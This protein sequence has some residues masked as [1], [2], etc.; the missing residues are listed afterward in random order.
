MQ[1]ALPAPREGTQERR[2]DGGGAVRVPQQ[3]GVPPEGMGRRGRQRQGGSSSSCLGRSEG[4]SSCIIPH[5]IALS[6]LLVSIHLSNR[7]G[8]LSGCAGPEAAATASFTAPAALAAAATA[9]EANRAAN[10]A[11]LLGLAAEVEGTG[12]PA[13]PE[14]WAKRPASSATL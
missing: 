11:N 6:L 13:A 14:G 9:S 8:L 2:T 10:S 12:R 7:R 3:L 4:H 1:A 5:H